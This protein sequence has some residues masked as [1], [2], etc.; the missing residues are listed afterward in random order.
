MSKIAT[1]KAKIS[2]LANDDRVY[3]AAVVVGCVGASL[4]ASALIEKIIPVK[5]ENEQ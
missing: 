1:A 3:I 4:A 5:E 2:K